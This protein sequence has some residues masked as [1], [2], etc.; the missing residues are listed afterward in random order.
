MPAPLRAWYTPAEIEALAK[1]RAVVEG[2]FDWASLSR[3]AEYLPA[4]RGSVTARFEFSSGS[5]GWQTLDLDY[6]ASV[7]VECQRCLGMFELVVANQVRFALLADES[8]VEH[9]PEGLEPVVTGDDRW[10][11]SDLIE[12]ELII[13]VPY[14]PKHATEVACR[15][16]SAALRK[17]SDNAAK[18]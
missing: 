9:V 4:E 12:D 14:A 6:H 2:K 16:H 18:Q 15:E 11:P 7:S 3:L 10:Q 1:R 17:Y 13:T 8:L 5:A